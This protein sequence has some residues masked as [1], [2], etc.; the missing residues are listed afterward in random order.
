MSPQ[1]AIDFSRFDHDQE[2]NIV[3]LERNMPSA[4]YNELQ[5]MG[6]SV[7]KGPALGFG[8]GQAILHLE[9]SWIAGS[10]YRKDGQ[11]AGF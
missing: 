2:K 7:A 5:E 3:S 6:H 4:L 1:A 9:D 11:A 8:G 10:D